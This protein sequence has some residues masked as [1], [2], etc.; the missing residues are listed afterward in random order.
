VGLRPYICLKIEIVLLSIP[1]Q[2]S[3]RLARVK[4]RKEEVKTGSYTFTSNTYYANSIVLRSIFESL[5]QR[6]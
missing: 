4:G 2:A 3:I 5:P 1:N 6:I